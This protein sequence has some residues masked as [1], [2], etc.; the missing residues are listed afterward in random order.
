LARPLRRPAVAGPAALTA[1]VAV[2]TLLHWVAGRRITGLWIMPDEAIYARRGLDLWHHFSLP[3][4]NGQGAGYSVLY[5]ALA[6]LPLAVPASLA[7]GYAWLKVV[8]ALVVSLAAVPVFVYG[9][10]LMPDAYALIAAALTV[11]SP[12]TLYSGFVMTEVLYYPLAAFALLA[13]AN[14]VTT[15]R[16]R[17]QVFTIAIVAAAIATRVQ[18]VVLIGVFAAAILLDAVMARQRSRLRSFWPVWALLAAIALAVAVAPGVF[19][20]YA[21]TLA[22][23][24]DAGNS[25]KFVYYHLAYIVLLVAVVPVAATGLLAVGALRGHERD[26]GARAVVA[27]AFATVVLVAIQVG[28]FAGRYAPHLLGRDLAAVPPILFVAF[29]LWLAR[30][31]PRPY[32]LAAATILGVA[33]VVLAAPW[34]DLIENNALPDTM[35]IAPF[36]SHAGE[37]PAVVIAFGVVLT[38]LLFLFTPRRFVLVMPAL[39]LAALAGSSVSADSLIAS[40]VRFDQAAMIGTPRD[41]INRAVSAPVAYV[42]AGDTANVNIVWQQQFWNDRIDDVLAIPPYAVPGPIAS[43]AEAPEGDGRLALE[44]RYVVANDDLSFVGRPLAHQ[45]RGEDYPGLTLWRLTG[46]PR[47]A[48]S[49]TGF[50]PNGDMYGRGQFV[51]WGCAGGQLQLTLIPKATND[52]TVTLDGVPALKAHIAGLEYWNGTVSVPSGHRGPCVFT[53]AGGELLGSTRVV[54]Q[55]A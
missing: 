3:I 15:A 18:A 53:I 28:T 36:L 48:T 55:P 6:G 22:G 16:A 10:R 26:P 37:R 7:H 52:V 33:A 43:R 41:W 4:L 2:S 8:Q 50:K 5:P 47:I 51:A 44:E 9:R 29:A 20:A 17:D 49:R 54:F 11:A 30:G 38:L 31:A 42:Y 14:A 39:A 21:G 19:G 32:V 12:L 40:K 25:A 23:G 45:D 46:P 24:Y 27:V 1:L 34:N 13:M 35:G